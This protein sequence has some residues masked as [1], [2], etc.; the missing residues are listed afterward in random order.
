MAQPYLHEHLTCVAAPAT[1]L[2]RASGQLLDGVDGL[3][4]NDRRLLS[5][6]VATVDGRQPEPVSARSIGA[7]RWEPIPSDRKGY[8]QHSRAGLRVGPDG[9]RTRTRTVDDEE[10]TTKR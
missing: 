1:W 10:V 8:S 6:L 9:V 7:R 3:D 2:S 4:V 5:R